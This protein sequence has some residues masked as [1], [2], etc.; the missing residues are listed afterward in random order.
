[1]ASATRWKT[2]AVALAS[3]TQYRAR[4]YWRL[5][6]RAVSPHLGVLLGRLDSLFERAEA[7]QVLSRM[8][9][10]LSN[11]LSERLEQGSSLWDQ[12]LKADEHERQE[13]IINLIARQ[14]RRRNF[15]S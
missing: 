12:Q 5:N 4:S 1:M 15:L 9:F 11:D 2:L 14:I 8:L 13:A 6:S 7:L 3:L 10:S